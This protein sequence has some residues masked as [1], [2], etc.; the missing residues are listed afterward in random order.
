MNYRATIPLNPV[1]ASRPRV[2]RR[3]TFY[4]KKYTQFK[5][6]MKWAIGGLSIPKEYMPFKSNIRCD[7]QLYIQMPKSDSKK[8][9]K[10]LKGR[11]CD[12]NADLDNYAKAILD[13]FNKV[14]YNDDRQIV[15]LSISK[16]WS[17]EGYF[18]I[19]IEEVKN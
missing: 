3:S 10:E 19:E 18:V 12:N 5:Q 1:P 14:L 15:E 4:P 6:D 9:K 17:E 7:I 8:K 16:R 2:T 11:Y 13:S